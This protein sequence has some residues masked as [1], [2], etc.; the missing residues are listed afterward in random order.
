MRNEL[1]KRF[2][3]LCMIVFMLSFGLMLTAVNSYLTRRNLE[4]LKGKALYTA[5]IAN[6]ADEE[7]LTHLPYTGESR[8][9]IIQPDGSVV[10]DNTIDPGSLENHGEREDNVKLLNND[11][12]NLVKYHVHFPPF[13]TLLE[14]SARLSS[15]FVSECGNSSKSPT[16]LNLL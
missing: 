12:T 9:T 1:T 2:F 16:T 3:A 8:L 13:Y 4:V 15:C 14:F 10:Y 7:L 5:A 6:S 11:L